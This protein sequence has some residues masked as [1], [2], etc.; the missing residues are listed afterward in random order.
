[1]TD[2][3]P[4][5]RSIT[6]KETMRVIL[7]R[8]SVRVARRKNLR[9]NPNDGV[10]CQAEDCRQRPYGYPI[11]SQRCTQCNPCNTVQDDIQCLAGKLAG[12]TK[13]GHWSRYRRT[14]TRHISRISG[15]KLC[16]I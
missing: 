9:P 4:V 14:P 5:R 6:E 12:F 13:S 15:R 8:W 16:D 1:M 11:K 7:S 3:C 10:V 2:S